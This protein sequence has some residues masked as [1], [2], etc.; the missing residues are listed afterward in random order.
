MATGTYVQEFAKTAV[1]NPD[2]DIES[3]KAELLAVDSA[4]N[5]LYSIEAHSIAQLEARAHKLRHDLKFAN[6][7][8]KRLSLEPLGWWKK[9]HMTPIFAIYSLYQSTVQICNP[10]SYN[11]SRGRQAWLDPKLP[12]PLEEIYR[13]HAWSLPTNTLYT[14]TFQG[15]IPKSVKDAIV[16]AKPLFTPDGNG[17]TRIYLIGEADWKTKQ[18]P[19]P[20]V[21]AFIDPL[22]VG[23]DE[24]D[25]WLISHFD[26]TPLERYVMEEFP[27]LPDRMNNMMLPGRKIVEK[28]L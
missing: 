28:E 3:L 20:P 24:R 4:K 11:T 27:A 2:R 23:W 14:S 9:W 6:K 17:P 18:M 21:P 25:L 16:E 26:L 10:E 7:P 5:S 12:E 22:V 8:Y 13:K 19:L 1:E 15:V